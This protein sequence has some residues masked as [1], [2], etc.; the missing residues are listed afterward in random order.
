MQLFPL[1]YKTHQFRHLV[2]K[3]N[4]LTL[5]CSQIM[6][7]NTIFQSLASLFSKSICSTVWNFCVRKADTI[8]HATIFIILVFVTMHGVNTRGKDAKKLSELNLAY[9]EVIAKWDASQ[10]KKDLIIAIEEKLLTQDSIFLDS[11]LCLG[12]GALHHDGD[13][14]DKI[15]EEEWASH[16][17]PKHLFQLLVFG[18]VLDCLRKYHSLF[19]RYS[20]LIDFKGENSKSMLFVSKIQ[21]L[22]PLMSSRRSYD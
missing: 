6:P 9:S 4:K 13:C 17:R 14:W 7:C 8:T 19:L 21:I 22:V 18:T 2:F 16:E 10:E 20:L 15:E 3:Y 12:P 1:F 11:A 5:S